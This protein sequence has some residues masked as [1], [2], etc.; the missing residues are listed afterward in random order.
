MARAGR[1][2]ILFTF[3]SAFEAAFP[4]RM[5]PALL[6]DSEHRDGNDKDSKI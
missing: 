6:L 4:K 3:M 2:D 1:E 5:I